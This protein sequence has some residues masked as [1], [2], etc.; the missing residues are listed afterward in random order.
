M[1]IIKQISDLDSIKLFESCP[2]VFRNFLIKKFSFGY[3][4]FP[5]VKDLA[6]C[7]EHYSQENNFHFSFLKIENRFGI[8]YIHSKG[9]DSFLIRAI[10]IAERLS[11]VTCEQ[12]GKRG[13]LYSRNG[14]QFS[15]LATL[16]TIDALNGLY[17]KL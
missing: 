17:R 5:I 16:C 4:W 11:Y 7:V 15:D 10:Q 13:F 9:L 1:E 14:T 6:L 8:L 12:C 3:G 2:F